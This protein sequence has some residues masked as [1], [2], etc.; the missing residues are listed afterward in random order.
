MFKQAAL[1]NGRRIYPKNHYSSDL[2]EA[3]L[4]QV[5]RYYIVYC[6]HSYIYIKGDHKMHKLPKNFHSY[7]LISSLSPE[8]I[9]V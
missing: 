7:P 1:K 9:L 6:N 2:L 5:I 3:E 8:T 4:L